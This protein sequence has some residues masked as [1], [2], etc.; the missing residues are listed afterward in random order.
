MYWKQELSIE[1]RTDSQPDAEPLELF[2]VALRKLHRV[3][4][5]CGVEGV[6]NLLLIARFGFFYAIGISTWEM[7]S[8]C[9]RI[10]IECGFHRQPT[11]DLVPMQEQ[12]QRRVFWQSYNIERYSSATLG[13]P[14]GIS[15]D[16]IS[17]SLPANVGDATLNHAMA[18][19]PG[20]SLDDLIKKHLTENFLTGMTLSNSQTR[21]CQISSD[22]F[23]S[24]R[25]LRY[26]TVAPSSSRR[27]SSPLSGFRHI[28]DNF[29]SGDEVWIK[30][31][32]Y[33]DKL[34]QWRESSKQFELN[35][36]SPASTGEVLMLDMRWIDLHS[37]Q[38]KLTLIRLVIE[39]GINHNQ[40]NNSLIDALDLVDELYDSASHII[41]L[42][43]ELVG[44]ARIEPTTGRLYR[45]LTAGLSILYT[46]IIESQGAQN[47]A[48][49]EPASLVA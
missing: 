44:D 38:E 10:C 39:P 14:F 11:S 16:A 18:M 9:L 46:I 24:L 6:Q 23:L 19:F 49:R 20:C 27:L 47:N 36:S 34:H 1:G 2:S 22:M 12:M 37:Y 25:Q 17:V 13:R 42:Y 29:T 3:N 30:Y 8:F 35:N 48:P 32:S 4:L 5:S 43:S 45:V 41:M 28:L 7:S 40:P 21:L 31:C 26:Q 33:L 15:D